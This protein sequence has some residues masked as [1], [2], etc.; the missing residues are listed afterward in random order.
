MTLTCEHTC[1]QTVLLPV[2]FNNIKI[3]RL[4][5]KRIVAGVLVSTITISVAVVAEE[6]GVVV[7]VVVHVVVLVLGVDI[8]DDITSPW[9]SSTSRSRRPIRK[10]PRGH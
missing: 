2:V 1:Q 7:V 8:E 3:R 4:R 6:V 10:F 5:R 9:S